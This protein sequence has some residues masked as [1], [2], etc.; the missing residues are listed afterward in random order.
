[1]F[2]V[3]ILF[4]GLCFKNQNKQSI[5]APRTYHIRCDK[6]CT[7]YSDSKDN[8]PKVETKINPNQEIVIKGE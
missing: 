7:V 5:K 4:A 1:M 3:T 8:S 6:P 2:I